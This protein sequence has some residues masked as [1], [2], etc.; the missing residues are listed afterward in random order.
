MDCR[1]RARIWGQ[2]LKITKVLDGSITHKNFVPDKYIHWGEIIPPHIK[3]LNW[4]FQWVTLGFVTIAT[5]IVFV[6][7]SRHKN[8]WMNEVAF[9]LS[10]QEKYAR[11]PLVCAG[12][13]IQAESCLV[14]LSAVV[15]PTLPLVPDSPCQCNARDFY[16]TFT[17]NFPFHNKLRN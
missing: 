7:R 12:F 2:E 4:L 8:E 10:P 5:T 6:I 17:E 1:N 14:S 9:I 13:S 15:L 16:F 3:G 11:L